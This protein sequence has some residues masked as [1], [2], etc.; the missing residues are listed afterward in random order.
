VNVTRLP[1]LVLLALPLAGP[2]KPTAVPPRPEQVAL[3]ALQ[4]DV[5]TAE[6]LEALK[7][8]ASSGALLLRNVKVVDPIAE[9]VTA[10]QSVIVSEG[11]FVWVGDTAKEP[12]VADVQI[13]DGA[14]RFASPGLTDMHVHTNGADAW[15]LDLANGVTAVRD[16]AGFPWM[17]KAREA[18]NGGRMLAPVLYVSGP[19]INGSALLG[20][21]VVPAHSLDARR[22]VRQQA[23]CGYD[24]IKVHNIVPGPIFDAVAQ[25]TRALGM[26]LVGH[27]PHDIK[28]RHA[29]ESGMRTMEHLK[30]FLDDSTLKA[31]ETDFGAA[32]DGP[33]VWNTPT[34]YAG[35]GYARA[36]AGRTLMAAPEMRY[37]PLRRRER[38]AA[39]LEEPESRG[40]KL[41]REAGTIMREIVAQ[42]HRAHARF[43][44]GTD[45]DNYPF[46]VMGFGLVEELALLQ[47]AGLAPPEALRAATSEPARAMRQG[48][49]FGQIKRGMRA[50]LVL[51]EA[52]PLA[53]VA[54]YKRNQG[55]MARG[56]WLDRALLDSALAKL[57]SVNSEPDSVVETSEAAVSQLVSRLKTAVG[58]GFVFN[59]ARLTALAV[60]SRKSGSPALADRLDELAD[61]PRVG[62]CADDRPR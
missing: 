17:L 28:V 51:L 59:A 13:I 56:L 32:V 48:Q 53:D 39:S 62:P 5:A 36:E 23:A 1:S 57:A 18:I 43:L 60:L 14:G 15:L 49:E 21:A 46:Q 16:M 34:L 4:Q 52:N 44:A 38:W 40:N 31:G 55:V 35:R 10:D 24:F 20:Y 50:D 33:E 25:Q 41:G 29:V 6:I 30:G 3:H 27:V 19:F 12:K 47:D 58:N 11:H 45:A 42:L 8:K 61:V 9:S 54:A 22:I 2:A 37:V 26:D 7:E